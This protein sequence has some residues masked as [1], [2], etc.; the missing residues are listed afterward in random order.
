MKS[1][2]EYIELCEIALNNAAKDDDDRTEHY[3]LMRASVL[4]G[5]AHVAAM[6]DVGMPVYRG[7][8]A[9]LPLVGGGTVLAALPQVQSMIQNADDINQCVL[10]LFTGGNYLIAV[11]CDRA[12]EALRAAS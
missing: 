2:I 7:E 8:R 4:S 12:L 9:E 6:G 11:S 1:A 3:Y 5:L 10:V